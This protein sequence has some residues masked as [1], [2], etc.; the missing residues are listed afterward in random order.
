MTSPP[1][2]DASNGMEAI[3]VPAALLRPKATL[4]EQVAVD[5]LVQ[6]SRQ[7]KPPVVGRV[8][9]DRVG[10]HH[11]RFVSALGR[12]PQGRAP[13]H[14]GVVPLLRGVGPI[15]SHSA[16]EDAVEKDRICGGE[17]TVKRLF[18]DT[19]RALNQFPEDSFMLAMR[20]ETFEVAFDPASCF[21]VAAEWGGRSVM[22]GLESIVRDD[23]V[24]RLSTFHL[25][26]HDNVLDWAIH[27]EDGGIM[28]RYG[29]GKSLW[30]GS[31]P[32][33]WR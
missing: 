20:G 6:E 2:D 18:I 10:E 9:E 13:D 23:G 16:G 17:D 31:S 32:L 22:P 33:P 14:L 1:V 21:L 7:K 3:G 12:A 11:E 4:N 25:R 26:A 29:R 19:T 30:W 24:P 5:Q 28:S 8:V 15:P 27:R